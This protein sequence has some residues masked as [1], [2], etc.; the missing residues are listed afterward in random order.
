MGRREGGDGGAT[1]GQGAITHTVPGSV[2]RRSGLRVVL[3]RTALVGR[4]RLPFVRWRSRGRTEEPGAHAGM[5]RL[6]SPDLDHGGHRDA[7]LQAPANG[8]VFGRA[9][10]AEAAAIDGRS[11]PGASRRGR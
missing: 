5:S 6:P 2:S 10:D 1:D 11:G 7:S 9:A 8:L 3:V 4:L